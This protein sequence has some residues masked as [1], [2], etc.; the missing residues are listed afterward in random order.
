MEAV[1]EEVARRARSS[2][3]VNQQSGVSARLGIAALE[4]LVAAAE[5]RAVR[6]GESAIVPRMSDLPAVVAGARGKLEVL[7]LEEDGA[8]DR[9]LAELLREA[10]RAVY[11]EHANAEVSRS[12]REWFAAG[13]TVQVGDEV[14]GDAILGQIAGCE[15]L[16]RAAREAA[17]QDEAAVG[18]AAEFL[19]EGMHLAG[20][21]GKRVEGAG[22]VFGR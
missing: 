6:H 21:I 11:A 22:A 20:Q 15:P 5:C 13:A 10:T 2:P 16:A 1:V 9:L 3:H 8:E 14:A 7:S 12:V 18:S 4:L 17:R 19:L